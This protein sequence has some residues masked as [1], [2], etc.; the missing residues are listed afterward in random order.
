VLCPLV[1]PIGQSKIIKCS[2]DV[3]TNKQ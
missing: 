3:P 1:D 2:V